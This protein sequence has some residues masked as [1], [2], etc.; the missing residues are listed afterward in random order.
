MRIPRIR[1]HLKEGAIPSIFPA[2]EKAETSV[3]H[4]AT[5]T[6]EDQSFVEDCDFE[7]IRKNADAVPLPSELWIVKVLPNFIVWN[8]WS[9]STLVISQRII[10]YKD[11]T[12][13]VFRNVFQKFV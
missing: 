1:V 6:H 3:T 7:K 13:K 12:V 11:M 4:I 8:S 5:E 9:D 10:L 2:V